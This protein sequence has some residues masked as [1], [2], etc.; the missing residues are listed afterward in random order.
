MSVPLLYLQHST[1]L[2]D[3]VPLETYV[4]GSSSVKAL[5]Q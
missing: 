4:A 2:Q 3:E 1:P 5:L